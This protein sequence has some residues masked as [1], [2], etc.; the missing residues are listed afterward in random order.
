MRAASELRSSRNRSAIEPHAS[1]REPQASLLQASLLQASLLQASLLQANCDGLAS[2][3]LPTHYTRPRS[4]PH[5]WQRSEASAQNTHHPG[6]QDRAKPTKEGRAVRRD[7]CVE[8]MT[9]SDPWD[10]ARSWAGNR[11]SAPGRAT[12]RPFLAGHRTS[13]L[14]TVGRPAARA[15]SAPWATGRA[16]DGTEPRARAAEALN[17]A[18]AVRHA[19]VTL[20]PSYSLRLGA[21]RSRR[22]S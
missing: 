5:D 19:N 13:W 4:K 18:R 1:A 12:A 2:S 7:S 21:V 3:V 9:T 20:T 16:A 6:H 11:T 22:C 8:P 17:M 15:Q 14:V 10:R